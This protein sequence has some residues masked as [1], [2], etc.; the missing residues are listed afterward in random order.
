MA[1][2]TT[3]VPIAVRFPEVAK[4]LPL[5]QRRITPEGARALE[6]LSHAID[7]LMDEHVYECCW[8][9]NSSDR[10]A[11]VELLME[12][13][14]QVYLDAPEIVPWS[15]KARTLLMALLP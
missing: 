15:E 1:T 11:A 14:K 2:T 8:S 5:R 10:L 13:R 6:K 3:A 12:R 9:Q 7:Y 4:A